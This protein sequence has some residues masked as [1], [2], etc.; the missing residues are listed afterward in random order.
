MGFAVDNFVFGIAAAIVSGTALTAVVNAVANHFADVRRNRQDVLQRFAASAEHHLAF[1]TSSA[2]LHEI[3][4]EVKS[5]FPVLIP[6]L[7]RFCDAYDSGDYSKA[8]DT[9]NSILI[10]RDELLKHH[11]NHKRSGGDKKRI[12]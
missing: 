9:M 11:V 8:R 2:K 7:D 5:C 6:D 4:G 10:R 1:H 12:R 3:C